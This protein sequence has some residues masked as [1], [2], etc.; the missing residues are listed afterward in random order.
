MLTTNPVKA[1]LTSILYVK[2]E[3]F[4][5]INSCEFA[6]PSLLTTTVL[7]TIK[8]VSGLGLSAFQ[9]AFAF[10]ALNVYAVDIHEDKLR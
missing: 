3:E 6:Q 2:I 7:Y 1:A 5:H 10:G 8:E 9:L 4:F